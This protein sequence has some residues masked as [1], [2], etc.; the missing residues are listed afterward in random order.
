MRTTVVD[1][2]F[3]WSSQ[4]DGQED[5]RPEVGVGKMVPPIPQTGILR[6]SK[7]EEWPLKR[8]SRGR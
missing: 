5:A 2:H 6:L 8:R 1:L 3:H 7:E 4:E